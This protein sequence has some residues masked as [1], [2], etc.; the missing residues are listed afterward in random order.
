MVKCPKCGAEN[1]EGE[2][3]CAKCGSR[4]NF[5]VSVVP[6]ITASR[7]TLSKPF[8]LLISAIIAVIIVVVFFLT[9]P[10]QL[11]VTEENIRAGNPVVCNL[12]ENASNGTIAIVKISYPKY[13]FEMSDPLLP[14]MET[15]M[16]QSASGKG[17]I[18]SPSE[19]GNFW[20]EAPAGHNDALKWLFTSDE[21]ITTA[22]YSHD[23]KYNLV[24]SFVPSI[25]DSEFEPPLG[26]S[27][28]PYSE[29]AMEEM[30]AGL[31]QSSASH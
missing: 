18:Y 6:A 7:F 15:I 29:D 10:H 28:R 26:A 19:F 20:W 17:Y 11:P 30:R 31:H 8:V 16:M 5:P 21:V 25:P 24:C 27:I 3:F 14:G 9:M 4:D 2:N 12:P 23:K 1:P 22:L 13:R